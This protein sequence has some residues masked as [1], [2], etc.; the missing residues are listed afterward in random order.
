MA[1]LS[2][3]NLGVVA[4]TLSLGRGIF[5]GSR[6]VFMFFV[7]SRLNENAAWLNLCPLTDPLRVRV[8]PDDLLA[9][10]GKAGFE[11]GHERCYRQREAAH[12]ARDTFL[13]R[14]ARV[15]ARIR[16]RIGTAED[17]FHCRR[18]AAGLLGRTGYDV[19]Q[20]QSIDLCADRGE[21]PV[22][23][24]TSAPG[25]RFRMAAHDDRHGSRDRLRIAIHLVEIDELARE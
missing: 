7:F 21:K 3:R 16:Q 22:T 18:I 12:A 15:D 2:R 10:A 6:S 5:P 17:Q 8:G 14:R 11:I 13:D 4:S 9:E 23:Q 24:T 25:G 20:R 1:Y 19:E